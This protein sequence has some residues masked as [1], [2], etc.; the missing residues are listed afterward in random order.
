MAQSGGTLTRVVL[1]RSCFRYEIGS[2][3]VAA[4]PINC[5]G[6]SGVT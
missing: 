1:V 6:H 5:D 4:E 3:A 2:V